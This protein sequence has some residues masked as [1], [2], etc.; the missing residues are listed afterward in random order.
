MV[1]ASEQAITLR[2]AII[3]GLVGG[4]VHAGVAVFLWNSWFDNLWGMIETKPLNGAYIILGMFLLGFIPVVFYLYGRVLSPAIIVAVS[5]LLSGFG[6]WLTGPVRAP[7]AVPTPFALYI[8][9]WVGVVAL[10]ILL[11]GLERW[12]KQRVT[13]CPN[14]PE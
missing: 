5:L 8:L 3:G 7:S 13:D 9:L 6:S 4:I 2:D 1:R 10:A 14:C 11:G 12:H